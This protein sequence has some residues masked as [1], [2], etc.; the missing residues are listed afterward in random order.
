MA[1]VYLDGDVSL[2]PLKGKTV[3]IIG[4]GSQGRAQAL[5]MRDSGVNV[6]LGLRPSGPSWRRAMGEGFRVYEIGEAARRGDV[7]HL[8]VPDEVQPEVYERFIKPHME[9]GK[10]LSFSHGFNVVYGLIKPPKH[11]DVVMVAP[12]GPG[13][14]VREMFVRGFGVPALVAVE[15]DFTG[16]A[17]Q[18]ALAMAKAIGATRACVIETSFREEVETDNFG[19]QVVL[20]GGVTALIKSAF[21][22]LVE[23]GYQPEVAYFEV[24]NE[25]KLIVDLI[26]SKGIYGMWL[27]VSNTAKYGGLTR[28]RR[29]I[30]EAVR[31]EMRKILDEVRRGYFAREW[32]EEY[33][34]GCKKMLSLLKA[35]REHPIESVGKLLRGYMGLGRERG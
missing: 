6:I 28:G 21:E 2:E 18:T 19:E 20:C 15:N 10:T 13:A 16:H 3:A 12:K 24:L 1:R 30:N 23:A 22:V 29:V 27:S 4:Y 26:Y 5:N 11:V 34:R 35:E 32:I 31:E 25:L 33:R 7:V 14:L 17:K 9:P 8:L